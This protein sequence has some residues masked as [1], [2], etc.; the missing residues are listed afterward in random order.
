AI[1][2]PLKRP[3]S[4]ERMGIRPPKGILLYGPPG[5][6]KTLLAKAVAAESEANF[7]QV[8]GPELLSMWVGESEK[9]LRKIFEKARQAS[10]SIVFF[11]EIDAIA[12]KRG[13]GMGNQATERMVNQLLSEMDGLMELNDVVIMAATNRPDMIDPALLRPGR[14]DR[15]LLTPVPEKEGRLEIFKIHTKGMPLAKEVNLTKLAEKTQNHVGADIESVCREA[16]ML[17]LRKDLNAKEVTMEHF[18]EALKKV[19]PSITEKDIEK[20]K[21]IESQYIRTARGAAIREASYFG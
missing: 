16:A 12:G 18:E 2:W 3:D 4:F 17:A 1:E 19:T 8:K 9:G 20:Y 5:T 7:I 15:L 13:Q 10:P 6:G 11:D 21:E 14:F